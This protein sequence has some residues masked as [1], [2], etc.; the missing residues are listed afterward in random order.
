MIEELLAKAKL[1][2]N[3]I[4]LYIFHQAN[5]FINETLRKKMGIPEEKFVHCMEKTGNTVQATIPIAI[6]ESMRNGRL[7]PGMKVL[8]AGFGAGLSWAS[9]IVQF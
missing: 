3:D 9:T 1:T 2:P 8:L 5:A 6:H 7:K 4:D